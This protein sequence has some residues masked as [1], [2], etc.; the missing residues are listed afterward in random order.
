MWRGKALFAL[1]YTNGLCWILCL[2][3]SFFG[4]VKARISVLRFWTREEYDGA[5]RSRADQVWNI[6]Y[7]LSVGLE[8]HYGFA[9]R[10]TETNRLKLVRWAKWSEWFCPR[11]KRGERYGS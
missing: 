1:M 5:R 8:G 4:Q 3:E 7:F 11:T 10:K 9:R 2:G 6:L